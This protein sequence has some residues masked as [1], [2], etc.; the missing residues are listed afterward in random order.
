MFGQSFVFGGIAGGGV[1]TLIHFLTVAGGGG[2]GNA[3]AGIIGGGGGGGFRTSYGTSGANSPAE[4]QPTF[5]GG[6]TYTITVGAGGADTA[7]Y[8]DGR[9]NGG[10]SSIVGGD[11]NISS[12]GGGYAG[13][14]NYYYSQGPQ[15]G[16]SGAGA[17]YSGV[18]SATGASAGTSN[19]GMAGRVTDSSNGKL[20]SGGGGG[21]FQAGTP[22]NTSTNVESKGGQGG[23]TTIV[24]TTNAVSSLA[25]EVS[26][27][28]LYFA[29]GGQGVMSSTAHGNLGGSTGGGLGGGGDYGLHGTAN[30]GG[31]AGPTACGSWCSGRNGG[32]GA[33][34][35][36]IP[37]EDYSG[38]VTGAPDV[39]TEGSDKV[40]VYTGSG[41]YTH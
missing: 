7:G 20:A 10:V 9:G 8:M 1:E 5:V 33:V 32:S 11:V 25:G 19:Q 22:A 27:G 16:G 37:S 39:Y 12:L 18:N 29:G 34:I 35:L 28:T 6:T 13:F 4:P 26:G 24:S 21:A 36:R 2:Q 15:V 40:L 23:T 17:G 14:I 3:R 38:V 41:S 31:G 30:T